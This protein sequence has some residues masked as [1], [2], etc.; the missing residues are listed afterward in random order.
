MC[1]ASSVAFAM[2]GQSNDEQDSSENNIPFLQDDATQ[3]VAR[4]ATGYPVDLITIPG[5]KPWVLLEQRSTTVQ[6]V[7][8]NVIVNAFNAQNITQ[9][10]TSDQRE[11][12]TYKT[13]QRFVFKR[14]PTAQDPNRRCW[15]KQTKRVRT[16]RTSSVIDTTVT[17]KSNHPDDNA[18][19]GGSS[20]LPL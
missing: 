11:K 1:L 2:E 6:R 14:R 3:D 7:L 5:A 8:A 12:D 19:D 4:D 10:S 17:Y 20:S 13:F 15:V 18:P 9:V 16:Q